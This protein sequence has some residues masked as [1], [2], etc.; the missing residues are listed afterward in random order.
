MGKKCI[1]IGA[2]FG[3][4]AA[5][6]RMAHAGYDV[7]LLEKNSMP[8][9]RAMVHKQDG[10]SFDMGPSWYLMPD[11]FERFFA[12]F[13]KKS[14]D[15]Y[16]LTQLSPSYRIYFSTHDYIDMP[17]KL[18]DVYTLFDTFEDNGGEK[19]KKYLKDAEY[20]YKTA[21]N[22]FLY[23]EY[24]SISDFISIKIA[25]EGLKLHVFENMKRYV[26]RYFTS[27]KAAKIVQYPLVFL[28]GSPSNTPAI[29]SLMSHVD[30]TLGV[31]YPQGGMNAVATAIEGIGKEYGAQFIY[32]TPVQKIE[33]KEGKKYVYT[34]KQRYFADII[35]NNADYQF[36]ET[37]LLQP[38]FQTY[39]MSYW[40]KRTLAPSGFILYLGI[41]KKLPQLSHHT[42]FFDNDWEKHFEDIFT[43]PQWPEAPSYYICAP[44]KTDS[45]VAPEHNENLF[46]L[47]PVASG[48]ED[49]PTIREDYSHKIIEH[50]CTIL[51]E[52]IKPNIVTQKSFAH[53]DFST[54]F[55]AYKGTA[56]GLSHTI[57]QTALFRPS[58]VSKKVNDLYYVGHYTH[59]GIGVPMALI[60]ADIVVNSIINNHEHTS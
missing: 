2:G 58:H 5:A 22:E 20:K 13:S 37:Q 55:N 8:G 16:E 50:L 47:V 30:L 40:E 17:S 56:L 41:N 39:P 6:A 59:P 44:S 33:I 46:I 1:I 51:D 3:G 54:L 38:E 25:I 9:G 27:Q 34:G 29:Y 52:D 60:S 4:L 49:T 45:T 48:L 10:F 24:T 26:K 18:E 28:G 23:K 7:T 53:N 36:S 42:L 43:N 57:T 12:N 35:I 11:I 21:V 14:S 19:L 32:N 15:Y 31:W